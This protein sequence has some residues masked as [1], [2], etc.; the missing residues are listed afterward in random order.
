MSPFARCAGILKERKDLVGIGPS[1]RYVGIGDCRPDKKPVLLFTPPVGEVREDLL[2]AAKRLLYTKRFDVDLS[3]P[4][5]PL[6]PH[7]VI[8]GM[9][10]MVRYLERLRV[11]LGKLPYKDVRD[12]PPVPVL[13]LIV[14]PVEHLLPFAGI[15]E[16]IDGRPLSDEHPVLHLFFEGRKHPGGL[17]AGQL[18]EP[19]DRELHLEHGGQ[20]EQIVALPC[21]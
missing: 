7:P 3:R 6:T 15:A 5:E 4:Y 20:T 18:L 19:V 12:A 11:I 9:E 16:S 13:F 1:G 8:R 2:E 21:H 14:E 10:E 17:H